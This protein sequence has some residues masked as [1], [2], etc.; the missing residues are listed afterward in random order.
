MIISLD[1]GKALD[2]IQ[3]PIMIK[4]KERPE[5]PRTFF[6]I[7]MAIYSKTIATI[8]LKRDKYKGILLKSGAR[9]GCPLSPYLF[10]IAHEVLATTL[11]Q[12]KIRATNRKARSN[13]IYI[14]RL[15]DRSL[16][17]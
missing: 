14:Y 15:C 1:A 17:C 6:N 11:R 12:L 10:N 16:F 2:K 9:Q 7:L 4:V 3:Q 8:N 13:T 5:I